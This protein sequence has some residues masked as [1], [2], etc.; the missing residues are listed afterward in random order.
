MTAA[1]DD[2]PHVLVVDDDVR[3]RQ[4]LSRFLSD[5]G[6]LVTTAEDAAAAG[7]RLAA[8][9]FD[10]LVLDVMMPDESGFD[11]IVRLRGGGNDVP[12]LLLTAMGDPDSRI[13]GLERGA[14]DYLPKPFEPRELLLRL[15]NLLR[16]APATAPSADIHLGAFR[17]D[18][19]RGLLWQGDDMVR[20]TETEA[21][22]LVALA[23]SP[24]EP[25]SREDL[26][27]RCGIIGNA[28]TVD[29]QVTRLRRKI[30]PDPRLPRYLQTMRGRG[31]VLYPD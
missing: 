23:A 11:F 10:A 3:L 12:V 26:T 29:V 17:F 28:R 16:R 4:L 8:V 19:Q 6:F 5:N 7:A 27:E 15:R 30:E 22:L 21:A 20:L 13:A 25:V 1:D 2:Q 31:Y 14:D 18:P 24:G 9:A